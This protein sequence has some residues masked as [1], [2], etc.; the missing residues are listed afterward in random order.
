MTDINNFYGLI[1]FLLAADREGIKPVA[2]VVVEK[3][4]RELF[5]A[6]VMDRRGY[7]N[8][9]RLL[10]DNLTDAEGTFDPVGA[11]VE[12]GWE[13]LSVLSPHSDV[14][15]RL[16]LRESDG[17]YVQLTYGC[18]FASLVRFARDRG[19]PA[20]AIHETVFLDEADESLYPL[21]RA[22]DLNTTLE[23]V[24]EAEKLGGRHRFV[25][26][27]AVERLF[28][29]VPEALANTERIARE[30]NVSGIINPQRVFPAFDGLSEEETFRVLSRLCDEGVLRRY[31]GI[32]PDIRERLDYELAVIREKGFAS[33]FLVVRDIVRQCPRTCGRGSAASSIVSY[34]LGIAACRPPAPHAF[35]RALPQQ[36][37]EE[38][39]RTSTWISPGTNG[40]RRCATYSRSTRAGPPWLPT[41][42]P[43]ARAPLFVNPPRPSGC[44]KR[45]SRSLCAGV[46]PGTA[47]RHSTLRAG[48][49]CRVRPFPR[50]LGTHCGGVVITPGP[51]TDY[52]HV[53]TSAL[54]YP[55][56]AW[57]KDATEDA[58]L[59]KIDLSREQ[60][61][62]RPS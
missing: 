33:Y 29:A 10:T 26:P 22:M 41:T 49:R 32:R 16:A 37:Q 50:N 60:V 52:T 20:A 12:R 5:T 6:Y 36:G 9:C 56:I 44:R 61:A 57:E 11:L 62:C 54:G 15:D 1:L 27:G 53:Q 59:V 42:S 23:R 34:L 40:R 45:S 43:S 13:G 18:P 8:I 24:P 35:L 51:V 46:S 55:L 19:L 7:G 38:I 48:S 2:G 4:G 14:I 30:A 3:K 58:G 25:E 21:L 17:L 47:G 28:S 31:G 39:R